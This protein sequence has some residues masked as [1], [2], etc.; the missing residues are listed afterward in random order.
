MIPDAPLVRFHR[1]I[2]EKSANN[3]LPSVLILAL[4]DSV[5]AGA[6]R[7]DHFLHEA[8]YHAVLK[9]LL[10]ERYP[11]CVFSV[12]NA[13]DNG[14]N[15]PG[16]IAKLEQV[17]HHQPDLFLIGFGLNDSSAGLAGLERY[18][19]ALGALIDRARQATE[20]DIIL[21]TPN[22]KP[23][24]D[25]GNVA[26]EWKDAVERFIQNQPDGIVAA[27]A[28]RAAEVGRDRGVPVAD[29]YAAWEALHARGENPT[30]MLINGLNHPDEAGHRLAAN[31][32]MKVIEGGQ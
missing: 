31:V 32:I 10:Q 22:M 24:Y 28:Q 18:A 27:Y 23:Y 4:G 29:V 5:T 3:A 8:V 14:Q 11:L 13:G 6:G 17:L 30:E 9:R 1:R 2:A 25:N 15:A 26:E 7:K 19:E 21:L 16:G 20:A 12:I